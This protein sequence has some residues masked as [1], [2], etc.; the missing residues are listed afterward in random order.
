M[1]DNE[2][3]L[4]VRF[5][6]LSRS[7]LLQR[8]FSSVL[9]EPAVG[10]VLVLHNL[11]SSQLSFE[12]PDKVKV[13]ELSGKDGQPGAASNAGLRETTAQWVG[14]LDSDDYY[15]PGAISTMLSRAKKDGA[16]GIIAP[17]QKQGKRNRSLLPTLKN[18]SLSPVKDGLFY[19]AAPQ[20]LFDRHLMTI[21]D[22]PFLENVATGEDIR[23]TAR[24]WTAPR[25]RISFYPKDPAYVLSNDAPD[26]ASKP[27]AIA[28]MGAAWE[29]I[30]QTSFVQRWNQQT[31]HALAV[32]IART[33][34]LDAV[35][36][37]PEVKDWDEEDLVWMSE[38]LT[39]L[40]REDSKY[41]Y[42]LSRSYAMTLRHLERGELSD[43]LKSLSSVHR[44]ERPLH[45]YSAITERESEFRWSQINRVRYWRERLGNKLK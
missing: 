8:C 31:R 16:N 25:A 44:G 23:V 1:S 43:A 13:V 26:R 28:E 6:D 20:G 32:K 29:E 41:D 22:D 5:H 7:D 18:S 12:I 35:R 36:Q 39:R 42:P 21:D 17:L 2:V 4:I 40:R 9:K 33:H 37:R 11:L 24:M 10:I 34:V 45:R 19:R 14:I 15:H 30:W 3:E 27:R 38:Y